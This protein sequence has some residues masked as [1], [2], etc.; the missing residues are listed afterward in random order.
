MHEST[1]R[2]I[3]TWL[4]TPRH[5]WELAAF[6]LAAA[7]VGIVVLFFLCSVPPRY[8]KTI[9]VVVTFAAGLFYSL[10]FLVPPLKIWDPPANPLTAWRPFVAN[11]ALI[12]GSFALLLGIWNLLH[13]HGRAVLKRSAGWYN[14]AAFY[15]AFFGIMIA[16]FLRDWRANQLAS[17]PEG[18]NGAKA[19][20]IAAQADQQAFDILLNGFL[21]S[22]EA[23]MFSLIAFYIVSAAYRAFRIRSTEAAL[24]MAAAAVIMLALVPVGVSITDWIP[25]GH[26]LSFLRVERIGYWLLV[27]PNMAAQRAIGFGIAVGALAT[28]LRI[29]LSLERGSFFDRQL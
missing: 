18:S 16:G 19:L 9:I 14:S 22:L 13:I 2:S 29:W 1:L 17:L 12:V 28:G 24:M 27:W 8:R 3:T 20:E 23:T 6:L 21:I 15:V 25:Q 4:S 11:A 26:F 7:V 10:E 5:G